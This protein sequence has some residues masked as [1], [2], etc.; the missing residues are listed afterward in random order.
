MQ[1]EWTVAPNDPT[2]LP[3]GE[4][5][6][7]PKEAS[8]LV[9][10][11]QLLRQYA[12]YLKQLESRH[13]DQV[14]E[15]FFQELQE[16][17]KTPAI[18]NLD[19]RTAWCVRKNALPN[20]LN[21]DGLDFSGM[22]LSY[23]DLSD[24]SMIGSKIDGSTVTWTNFS[25]ANLSLAQ[26]SN[27]TFEFSNFFGALALGTFFQNSVLSMGRFR[28]VAA[29]RASFEK[30]SMRATDAT[31]STYLG[32][33]FKDADVEFSQFMD[34]VNIQELRHAARVVSTVVKQKHLAQAA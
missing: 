28:N 22:D 17:C 24:V 2:L 11:D 13:R 25:G 8:L 18:Q 3:E 23:L 33:S 14:S 34:S 30:T 27:S 1:Q 29:I 9:Q 15:R 26:L 5:E 19:E 12:H 10:V 31:R 21:F 20:T 16:I 32:S 4:Y 6:A 7:S